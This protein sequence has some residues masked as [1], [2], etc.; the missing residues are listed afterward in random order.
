M[1]PSVPSTAAGVPAGQPE[2]RL[3]VAA[4]IEGRTRIAGIGWRLTTGETAGLVRAF[5]RRRGGTRIA[6]EFEA[7]R[8][9]LAEAVRGGCRGLV[10]RVPDPRAV[11]LLRGETSS[12]FRRAEAMAA[13]LRPLLSRFP[14]LRFESSF[15]AD[16]ELAHAV[17]EAL[18]SGLHAAAEREEHR[19]MIME[20]ILERAKDVRLERTDTGWVANGRYH[21]QLDPMRCECPAWTARWARTPIAGRR[22]QRLPCKHIVALALHEGITVPADLAQMARRAP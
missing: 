19:V 17:G 7:I 11:A 14:S 20:R 8:R 12:R 22:A 16:P 21:V 9:G 6:S 18:D 10:L 2:C 3:E 13:R 1:L 5:T 4:L 15:K